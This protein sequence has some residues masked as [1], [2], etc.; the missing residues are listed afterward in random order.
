[1][2][3][4]FPYNAGAVEAIKELPSR[5]WNPAERGWEIPDFLASA[6]AVKLE[7]FYPDIAEALRSHVS[8]VTVEARRDI[9]N[10]QSDK[11]VTDRNAQR[12][13]EHI[14]KELNLPLKLFPYQEVGVA[15]I[16]LSKGKALIGDDMG[17][18]KTA[19]SLAW[20]ALHKEKRPVIVICPASVKVNWGREIDKWI[21]NSTF[22]S[23]DSGK[24]A[25]E[26]GMDFYII[27]Y[28]LLRKHEEGLLNIKAS[29]VILDESTYIKERK[30]QRT[31]ATLKIAKNS[32]HVLAL[33]G[34]PILNKPMEFFNILNLLTPTVF[35]SQ[36]KF[37]EQFCGMEHNGYGFSYSGAT[38]TELLNFLLKSIMIRREKKEVLKDLPPKRRE[39]MYIGI[40][41]QIIRM[42]DAA[43]LDLAN[44]VKDYNT[45]GLS[46]G[47]RS[48]RR[49]LAITALGYLR[50]VVG[51]AKAEQT[52]EIVRPTLEAG[53]KIVIFG[54]HK[55][56]LDKL[57]E[58]V[59][60]AGYANVR[61]D[62]QVT[63]K[64]RQKLI[65][66]FQENP[67]CKVMIA[68]ILAM[69]MGVNL[70]SASSVFIVERQWTPA[71][72]EQGEDRLWRIGQE[73]EVTV[74]Y[75]VTADTVDDKMNSLIERK[76]DLVSRIVDGKKIS[77]E[78][79][80]VSEL[81]ETYR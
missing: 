51:M 32:P 2:L 49:M 55:A 79:S 40:P 5:K 31:K 57:E 67:D 43:E 64:K 66:E 53:E 1:M 26:K 15:F 11:E 37:G 80:L 8:S 14:Q 65:D 46:S 10:A 6:A 21:P 23:I 59:T 35:K 45:R 48:E 52:L 63:G 19:Q 25:I 34:T 41:N 78:E 60:K 70:V 7:P 13:L 20:L 61:I 39:F 4:Q 69:G 42:H 73:K 3:I 16:E 47:E 38:N 71:V 17:L 50:Q 33:S 77:K 28:D 36:Y 44:A 27:N 75:L 68:S 62:G 81:L 76:R 12:I 56:V 18:G 30:S 54:H 29:V 72:E 74:W 58:D 22:Q 24:D 9:S